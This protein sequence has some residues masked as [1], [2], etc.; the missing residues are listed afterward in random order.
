MTTHCTVANGTTTPIAGTTTCTIDICTTYKPTPEASASTAA[1]TVASANTT[2]MT[3]HSRRGRAR[4]TAKGSR[5]G[6]G[7]IIATPTFVAMTPG[8]IVMARPRPAPWL[9]PALLPLLP[10]VGG[11]LRPNPAT[12]TSGSSPCRL[13][14]KPPPTGSSVATGVDGD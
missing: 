8:D 11:M 4:I 6:S 2:G 3:T 5:S 1:I 13:P 14:T 12:S 10:R 9:R 7:R